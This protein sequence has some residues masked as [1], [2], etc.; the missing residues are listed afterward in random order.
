M[1]GGTRSRLTFLR[2]RDVAL[3]LYEA[4]R[5]HA[6]LSKTQLQ[7]MIYL[8]DAVTLLY[9]LLPVREGHHTYKH[10]PWDSAIQNAA[11][12][13]VFR[14]LAQLAQVKK[15]PQ[16]ETFVRYE[17]TPAGLR[18][19]EIL[20]QS[21]AARERARTFTAVAAQVN[22]QGWPRLRELVYAEP[23]YAFSRYQGYGQHLQ[24][25]D[26]DGNSAGN[27]LRLMT[28]T[29]RQGWKQVIL[30][31]DLVIRLFFQ[32]LDRYHSLTVAERLAL[33]DE[34]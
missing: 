23:T 8:V 22:V 20:L 33:E 21:T 14:G 18:W 27:L 1:M 31:P 3:A 7:K 26:P 5:Y 10:G 29:L 11:D 16:Y 28:N 12:S 30:D 9:A 24:L 17:L 32:Y 34:V 19:S 25:L 15:G 2:M 6:R 13:L 4:R